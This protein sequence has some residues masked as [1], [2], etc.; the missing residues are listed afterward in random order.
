MDSNSGF[1]LPSSFNVINVYDIASHTWW[2][3]QASGD[4]PPNYLCQFCAGVTTSLDNTNFYITIYGGWSLLQLQS[5]ETVFVLSLPSF[6]WINATSFSVQT[7]AEQQ[8]NSTIGRDQQSCQVYNNTQLLVLGG[9]IRAGHRS[10]TDGACNQVFAP[11]RALDLSTYTWQSVFDPSIAYKVPQTIYSVV[12]GGT[13]GGAKSEPDYGWADTELAAVMKQ[14]PPTATTSSLPTSTST[15]G[16]RA[17]ASA[18]SVPPGNGH[19]RKPH[20]SVIIGVVV[21]VVALALLAVAV[22]FLRRSRRRS[23]KAKSTA[24]TDWHSDNSKTPFEAEDTHL[25]ELHGDHRPHEA[26]TTQVYELPDRSHPV[27]SELSGVREGRNWK[28]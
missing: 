1:P 18:S 11:L 3:Q 13:G 16:S 17:T 24:M 28:P 20:T 9:N 25:R 27:P 15:P 6:T 14:R 23:N 4:A 22:W 2:A 12:G 7:N 5:Y 19:A 10:L 8:V 21:G 26:D